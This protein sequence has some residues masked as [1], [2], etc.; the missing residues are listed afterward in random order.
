MCNIQTIV[1]QGTPFKRKEVQMA[2][3]FHLLFFGRP[4]LE[5]EHM[6]G[7]LEWFDCLK[8]PIKH[9]C[10]TSGWEMAKSLYNVVQNHTKVVVS[11]TKFLSLSCDE[12]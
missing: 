8:L 12:V 6:H 9:W 2:I 11:G 5:Y 3:V 4:M 1:A 7:L 10:N